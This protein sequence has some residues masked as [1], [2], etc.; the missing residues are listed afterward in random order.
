MGI[1]IPELAFYE[2]CFGLEL[3]WIIL[4][5]LEKIRRR[6]QSTYLRLTSRRI[7]QSLFTL[8]EDEVGRER[9]RKQALYGAYR[10]VDRRQAS[11]YRPGENVVHIFASGAIMPEVVIAS[12]RL[13]EE[14][15]L[16]NVI[17]V[18]GSGPLYTHFQEMVRSAMNGGPSAERFMAD[19]VSAEER[20]APIVTVVDG[21]PHSLAWLGGALGARVHPLGVTGFGQSGSRADLYAEYGI[22]VENIMAAC[23]S[24]LE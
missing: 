4:D 21:H 3:E 2:P 7:D 10:L 18:T 17:N 16:A 1:E 19:V 5:A 24:A 15:V 14:G 11:D 13:L 6:E 23:F 12:E 22:D 9:L 20:D 8:P